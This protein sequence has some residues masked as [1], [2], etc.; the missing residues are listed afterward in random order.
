MNPYEEVPHTADWALRVRGA[1][2][3]ELFANAAAGMYALIGSEALP[4]AAEQRRDVALEAPDAESLLVAWLNELLYLT[5]AEGLAFRRFEIGLLDD[6]RL[7]A[8]AWGSLAGN[9]KKQ[10]KAVTFH[11]LQIR[12]TD[13]GLETT[14]VFDV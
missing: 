12:S 6:S 9:M 11:D 2:P 5:E 13:Q 14:I 1:T 4:G 7:Q 10:I 3:A 8:T